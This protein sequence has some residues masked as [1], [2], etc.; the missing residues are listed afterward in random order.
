MYTHYYIMIYFV[1]TL[2]NS[3]KSAL[4]NI[5]SNYNDVSPV[6]IDIVIVIGLP[7]ISPSSVLNI[8]S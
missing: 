8:G 2:V 7:A 1:N 4:L 3:T 6:V 5:P